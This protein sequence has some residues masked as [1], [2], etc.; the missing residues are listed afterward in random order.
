MARKKEEEIDK[1]GK[2]EKR[3][4]CQKIG[5]EK[6][7]VTSGKQYYKKK[8]LTGALKR[9]HFLFMCINRSKPCLVLVFV[10]F[11]VRLGKKLVV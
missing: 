4:R 6:I 8:L 11:Q 10:L 7:L 2:E 9:S 5:K 3:K 1:R